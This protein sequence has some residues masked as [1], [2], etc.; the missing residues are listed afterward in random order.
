[1]KRILLITTLSVT[2]LG[3][4]TALTV[5]QNRSGSSQKVSGFNEITASKLTPT[6]YNRPRTSTSVDETA[7]SKTALPPIDPNYDPTTHPWW[8]GFQMR[9]EANRLYRAGEWDAAEIKCRQALKFFRGTYLSGSENR[10]L[11]EILF[12]KGEYREALESYGVNRPASI[13]QIPNYSELC[14]KIGLCYI[15]LGEITKAKQFYHYA[16]KDPTLAPLTINLP[17]EANPR[18]LK[19]SL[20]ALHAFR[21]SFDPNSSLRYLQTAAELAPK[22]GLIAY[23]QAEILVDLKRYDEALPK[24]ARAMRFGNAHDAKDANSRMIQLWPAAEREKALR[25]AAKIK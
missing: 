20:L 7:S 3:T 23:R 5:A 6:N 24:Y 1:M 4:L 17:G 19:A 15:Q 11:G 9:N 14:I 25:E 8:P 10:L 22:N 16:L 13:R 21:F 18:A 2:I 12:E